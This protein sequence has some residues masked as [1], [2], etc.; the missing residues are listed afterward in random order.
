MSACP[1][2]LGSGKIYGI[3]PFDKRDRRFLEDRTVL[4]Y[5]M[6]LTSLAVTASAGRGVPSRN[7]E[8]L[9]KQCIIFPIFPF[10]STMVH[11]LCR[12]QYMPDF[13]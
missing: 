6:P 12:S 7:K 11:A 10:R 5:E 1:F 13:R 3:Q 4:N 8:H 2:S 9:D